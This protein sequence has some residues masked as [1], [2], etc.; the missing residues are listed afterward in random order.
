MYL[1]FNEE[2]I[3]SVFPSYNKIGAFIKIN[4]TAKATLIYLR[5]H[6]IESSF[7]C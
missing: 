7:S 1:F 3:T 6:L 2:K 5:V 4:H